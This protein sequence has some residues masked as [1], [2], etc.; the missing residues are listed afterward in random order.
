MHKY[1]KPILFVILLGIASPLYAQSAKVITLKDG[2]VIKGEVLRLED[3]AYTI[4]TPNLGKVQIP[5]AD[6]LT[7]TSEQPA[8]QPSASQFE[9]RTNQMQ[10]D[11]L[12]D[13]ALLSD[14]QAMMQDQETVA[15][16]S[17]PKL[18]EDI[19]SR[20]PAK[21]ESNPKVQT[22]LQNPHMQALI[23]KIQA[24]TSAQK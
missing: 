15:I 19:M 20:D 14:V 18:M 2:S 16:F 21:I 11:I 17:D 5:E 24:K 7:I 12:S 3:H 1:L 23:Q 22:L 13:P 9:S 8:A 4:E 6:I 10:A